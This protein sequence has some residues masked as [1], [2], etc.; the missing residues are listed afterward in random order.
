MM[1]TDTLFQPYEIHKNLILKNRI[2]MAPMT[3]AK[4]DDNSNPT[5]VMADYYAKRADAGL[6]ITE[7]TIISADAK[8]HTNTPGI[9]TSQH[10]DGWNRITDKV[11]SNG[12]HIFSQLWHVGRVS[13]P[14]FLNGNLPIAP[15]ET[16]MTGRVWRTDGLQYGKS[17]SATIGEIQNIVE[18]Y[19]NA[20]K[21]AIEA[22]FDGIEIH[23]ANGYLIDQFLHYH[24]NHRTD[25]YGE[26]P[27]NMA[28]F[29][30]EVINACGEAI[31]FSKIGVRLSPGGYL[32]QIVGDV[33]DGKVFQYLLEQ[34]NQYP[35]AYVHTG[36]FNDKTQFPELNN[37]TMT[38]FMRK[39]YKGTLI[40]SG[41]YS[42]DEAE[43]QIQRSEFDLIAIGRP[44][45]ANHDLINRL[46]NKLAI[47]PYHESMLT[48]LY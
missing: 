35:I 16:V 37:L 40:A 1:T 34:L 18:D 5:T 28:R 3:R 11:H 7:A 45:I 46:Q 23:G 9:F 8:G 15:S 42:F 31:G 38:G 2:V 30:L 27:E 6:I 20:A 13:H 44:F 12:G 33:R 25:V 19:V 10:I 4:A 17:R 39:H 36:N 21:N 43:Q 32:N 48:T 47:E 22:G 24:T 26:T 41:S 29:A 14:N